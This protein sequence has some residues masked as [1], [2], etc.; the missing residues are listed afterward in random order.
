MV[1]DLH[2]GFHAELADAALAVADDVGYQIV[3]SPRTSR[4][5][6]ARAIMTALEFRCEALLLLGPELT[7]E[8]IGRLTVGTQVICVGRQLDLS[9]VD[10]VRSAEDQGM[11]QVVDHLIGLGH[12]RIA[13]VDGG[14]GQ[15][16][17]ARRAGFEYGV[18][19][20]RLLGR[21][22]VLSGGQTERAGRQAAEELLHRTPLATAVAAFND[23]CALGVIDAL[24][25]AGLRVPEDVS[26]T[27]YDDSPPAQ[28][29]AI[30]LT[31]VRPDAAE[32]ARWAVTAAV[33]RLDGGR[34]E[35]RESVLTPRLIIRGSS[36]APAAG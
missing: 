2:N 24:T 11:E 22:L 12:R 5:G 29:A 21:S 30:D 7:A 20:R 34:A 35:R 8:E 15:I 9:G 18:R 4:H 25:R 19:R 36:A 14:P 17:A 1:L 33:E 31:S 13:H 26:V 16:A 23:H 32:L 28:L 6:E 10:I 27:G 3:L